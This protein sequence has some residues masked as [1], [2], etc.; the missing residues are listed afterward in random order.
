MSTSTQATADKAAAEYAVSDEL[1]EQIEKDPA[2]KLPFFVKFIYGL[3]DLG[4][5]ISAALRAF[6][7]LFFLTDVARLDPGM[8]GWIVLITRIWDAVNDPMIGWLS[9]R[10]NTRWGRRRPWLLF[11]AVPF[12][13]LLF[14]MW[15]VPPFGPWGL[16][17][18]YLVVGLLLD[19][20]YTMINV[21]YTA[22]TPELTRD[23]DERTSLNSFRA[24]VSVVGSVVAAGL[25]PLIVGSFDDPRIGYMVSAA[26]WGVLVTIPPLLVFA[27]VRER[28]ESIEASQQAVHMPFGQQ[29]KVAFSNK[30]YRFV[31]TL[32][33]FSW[34]ALQL[35]AAVM[36]YYMTYF[37]GRPGM[38]PVV[39]VSIQLSTFVFVFVWS[40]VSRKL[41]KRMVY[42]IG[43]SVWMVVQLAI[44]F[45]VGPGETTLL[46]LLAIFSGIGVSTAYLIPWSMMPDV[47]EFDEWETGNRR[48]GIFYGFMVFMQKT[49]IAVA[50]WGVSQA[51][52]YSGYITPTDAV[53]QPV[54]P[55]AALQMVRLFV[56]PLPA[57]ILALSLVVAYFYPISRH[58]HAEMRAA[59]ARRRAAGQAVRAAKGAQPSSQPA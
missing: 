16:F 48:E 10:T 38:L 50:I 44:Y 34:L 3:G 54:Q 41:D 35:T 8:A 32:Y 17:F 13:L 37:I 29:V 45:L 2:E 7:L 25:H 12:G 33:L 5:A 36:A 47:I 59:L 9:D 53:P 46:V 14:M 4:T 56:G 23:Y 6:F 1:I 27:V 40:A 31:I 21:P 24:G 19:S 39:L 11:G 18:Y 20:V 55:E 58:L 57:A 42:L 15:L 26:V 49:T 51:L 43:A 28:P 22:L 30:P 52:N